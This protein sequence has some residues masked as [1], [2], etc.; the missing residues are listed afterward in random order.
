[1]IFS[2]IA[3]VAHKLGY[4]HTTHREPILYSF[5]AS[6]MKFSI[7]IYFFLFPTMY[8]E[9]S[10]NANLHI[11][12][13]VSTQYIYG[14]ITRHLKRLTWCLVSTHIHR[15]PGY[16][17]QYLNIW[18]CKNS[19]NIVIETQTSAT[20]WYRDSLFISRFRNITTPIR[21]FVLWRPRFRNLQLVG[22]YLMKWHKLVTW[23]CKKTSEKVAQTKKNGTDC[24]KYS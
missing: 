2:A 1:M 24:S 10:Q 12:L 7:W 13:F 14:N 17:V 15:C 4:I 19:V 5:W 18:K 9:R 21:V 8:N 3:F 22:N 23:L 6:I 11:K 16:C 20:Q